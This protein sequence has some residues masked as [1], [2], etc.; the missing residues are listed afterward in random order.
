MENHSKR[1]QGD[2]DFNEVHASFLEGVYQEHNSSSGGGGGGGGLIC[3]VDQLFRRE[4]S[5]TTCHASIDSLM[6]VLQ[7][8]KDKVWIYSINSRK[9]Y[10]YV[11]VVGFR[12]FTVPRGGLQISYS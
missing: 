3:V 11:L 1:P 2:R 7:K 10:L 8:M 5:T 9:G 12:L 6:M 4:G